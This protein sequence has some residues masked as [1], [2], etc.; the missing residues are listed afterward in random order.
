MAVASVG[1]LIM[2]F[3][4]LVLVDKKSVRHLLCSA[5]FVLALASLLLPVCAE[6][7]GWTA[8]IAVRT[9]MGA[10]EVVFSKSVTA[11]F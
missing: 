4:T 7:I 1:G 9:L 6:Y 5:V 11:L 3:F 2:T 8:V 10:A